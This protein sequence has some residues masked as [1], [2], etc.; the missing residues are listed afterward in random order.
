MVRI[1]ENFGVG[2]DKSQ[3]QIRGD[4]WSQDKGRKRSFCLTDGHLS[5]KACRIGGKTPKVQRSSCSPR[6]YCER[7]SWV[8]CSIHTTRI[9]SITNDSS[10]SHGYHLQTAWLRW[11][12]SWRNI[13]FYPGKNGGCSQITENSQI[14][15][16]GHLDSSTTTQMAKVMVQYGRPSRSAWA[17]SVW[18]SFGRPVMGKAVWENPIEVRLG[19]GFRLVT[20]IHTSWKRIIL[21]CVCG[22]HQIDWKENKTLIRCGKY[23][24]KKSIWENQHLSLI[25]YTWA[26]LK[27]NVK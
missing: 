16:S 17:K 1:G 15:V 24:I 27:D 26:A 23:S 9:I 11:T 7:R 22:W 5:F 19:E 25:M 12:S 6:W 8:L 20:L 3:K 14:G 18:S 10:K 13:C 21:I 4:E 2:P